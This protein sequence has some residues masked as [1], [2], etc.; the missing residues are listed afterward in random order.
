MRKRCYIFVVRHD[1]DG[2]LR[3]IPIPVHWVLV[4][5]VCAVVGAGTLLG[6]A[7]SY[8]RLWTKA[9]RLDDLREQQ[10]TL[11]SQLASARRD[12]A[13]TRAEVASLGSLANEVAALYNLGRD[14]ALRRSTQAADEDPAAVYNAG[15]EDFEAL[16]SS[17]LNGNFLA[18]L[19]AGLWRPELWPV[20]GRIS[21][22]F[23]ERLDPFDGEGAFHT[24]IDIATPIGTP[25]HVTADGVVLYAGLLRGY[26]RAIVVSHGHHL[27]TLY[28]HLSAFST[29][30][31][32]RVDRGD[33][34]GFVGDSGRSTGPHLHYEVRINGVPVNPYQYLH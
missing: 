29:T 13:Q 17:A 7:G 22:S 20:A 15:V 34:I 19:S 11:V 30:A 31:G 12:A 23:G 26:G 8:T 9:R 32:Q 33:V 24:G 3:R 4:F 6:L 5:V 21:S 14:V 27:R 18:K 2:Q 28:A 16:E 1:W 25:V 10:R